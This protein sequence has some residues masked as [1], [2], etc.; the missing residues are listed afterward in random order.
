MNE[1]RIRI[2]AKLFGKPYGLASA[3]SEHTSG[4]SLRRDLGHDVYSWY[5]TQ[6][7]CQRAHGTTAGDEVRE[8]CELP[9]GTGR[10]ACPPLHTES[11]SEI[12]LIKC[13]DW[14]GLLM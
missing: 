13:D 14:I 6:A 5:V 11:N 12:V 10:I 7:E 8:A 3:G 1:N 2:E 4:L 9:R